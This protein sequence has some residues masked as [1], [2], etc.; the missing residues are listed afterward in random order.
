MRN[1]TKLTIAAA[2]LLAVVSGGGAVAF[3]G[4]ATPTPAPSGTATT[5]APVNETPG[6]GTAPATPA[7]GEA[8]VKRDAAIKIAQDKVPGA[9]LVKAEFDG[10]DT[11]TSWEVELLQG[12][13]EHEFDIDATTGAILEQD[14]ET[15]TAAE[16]AADAADD[17]N[18]TD[19]TDDDRDDQDDD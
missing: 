7:P 1:T 9:K 13:V 15:E 17:A 10:D 4:T 14:Q 3:A 11:P 19:D 12:D 18:D 8:K 16:R 6:T 2:G 5:P